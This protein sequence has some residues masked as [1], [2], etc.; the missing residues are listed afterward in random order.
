MTHTPGP[1]T[2]DPSSGNADGTDCEWH[3]WD[4][5]GRFR[6]G[7]ID[8]ICMVTATQDERDWS[9]HMA[10]EDEANARLIAA[11]PELLEACE[12]ASQFFEQNDDFTDGE[13]PIPGFI[14]DMRIAIAKA[15]GRRRSYEW[16][17][18]GDQT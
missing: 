4:I 15:K 2:I 9:Y 17:Q 10:V 11:A 3:G 8:N 5:N 6:T 7:E 18:L 13:Y 16:S 12:V 14:L 1:W